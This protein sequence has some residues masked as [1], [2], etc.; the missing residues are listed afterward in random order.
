MN[1][2]LADTTVLIEHLRGNERAKLFLEKYS[3]S[4]STVTIAELIQGS[5]DKRELTTVLKLYTSLVEEVIDKKISNKALDLLKRF[6]LSNGLLFLDALVAATAME[7]KLTLVTGN[8]KHFRFIK[9]VE[10][11][12]QETVFGEE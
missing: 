5:R 4:V 12:S 11:I 8:L 2:F 3:P 10:I 6:Y 7:N 9:G 1:K